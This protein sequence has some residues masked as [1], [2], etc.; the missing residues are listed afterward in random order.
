MEKYSLLYRYIKKLDDFGEYVPD[1]A[2][3]GGITLENQI[4]KGL[5]I[6]APY[7]RLAG[8]ARGLAA[9]MVGKTIGKK[10]HEGHVPVYISRFGCSIEEIFIA[11]PELKKIYNSRFSDIPP[12]AI[13][14]YTY[15]QRLAQ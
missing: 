15:F 12:G 11:A 13:G 6:G 9:A 14:V 2:V 7:N 10:I 3:A 4:Y 5:A 1:V 8:M